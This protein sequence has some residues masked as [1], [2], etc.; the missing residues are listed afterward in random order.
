MQHLK[1]LKKYTPDDK[2]S[3]LLI[4]EYNVEFLISDD[5]RDWYE[6]QGSF[7]SDTLKIA[8]DEAGIIR[9]ISNDVSSIY[10]RGFSVVEVDITKANKSVD[11]FGGW[12]FDNGEIKP[13]QYSQEELRAQAEAKK[14][15]LLSVAAS[16]IAPLQ[17]AVD[18]GMATAEEITMLSE[19]RQYR[20][21]VRRVDTSNPKWPPRPDIKA[22]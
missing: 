17:D 4:K 21:N 20:V 12:V 8:Y 7:S 10:P 22:S 13:R 1:N 2:E 5:G 15:E 19:W 9:S 16:A 18:E 3:Q 6:S 11:I 14:S